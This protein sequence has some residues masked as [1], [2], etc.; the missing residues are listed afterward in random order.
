MVV[1]EQCVFQGKLKL[2][3]HLIQ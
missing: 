3:G 2:N 1:S